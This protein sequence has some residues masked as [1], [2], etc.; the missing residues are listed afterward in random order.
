MAD[1]FK[2][3]ETQLIE[4]L[5]KGNCKLVD[6]EKYNHEY[7]NKILWCKKLNIQ[8]KNEVCEYDRQR[9]KNPLTRKKESLKK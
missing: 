5:S 6:S 4:C 8:C 9:S 3:Y 2:S 1:L 7:P